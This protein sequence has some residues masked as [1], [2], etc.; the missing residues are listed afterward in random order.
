[1]DQRGR[2]SVEASSVVACKAKMGPIEPPET[3]SEAE[4]E[5]WKSVIAT[6]P[7]DWFSDD[8]LPLLADYCRHIIRQNKIS[9]MINSHSVY[10]SDPDSL[11]VYDKLIR[12][13][14]V[15]SKAIM[16]LATKMRLT[17]QSRYDPK[18]ANTADKKVAKRSPWAWGD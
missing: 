15:E 13:S 7:R 14:D 6:K 9:D 17:Q 1:M 8:N 5:V 11:K 18:T 10:A 16:Q 2:K 12:L 3:L 4:G